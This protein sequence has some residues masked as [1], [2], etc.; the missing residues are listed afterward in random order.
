MK[1]RYPLEAVLSLRKLERDERV[2]DL[3]AAREL[4][5]RRRRELEEARL[6][7]RRARDGLEDATRQRR[8]REREGMRAAD[9]QAHVRRQEALE[10]V[11]ER[12]IHAVGKARDASRRASRELE[13]ARERLALARSEMRAVEK[14]RQAWSA[15][16]RR[17]QERR[18]EEDP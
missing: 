15:E 16:R 18:S 3:G 10:K 17:E 9:L 8:A 14:H 1:E 7:E 6:A 4:D 11:L 13:G 2:Q 12:R 5:A